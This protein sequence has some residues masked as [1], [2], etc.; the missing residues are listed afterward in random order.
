MITISDNAA[1]KIKELI[2]AESKPG[3]AFRVKVVAGGCSGFSYELGFDDQINADD[4][5]YEEKGVKVLLDA[6]SDT[7]VEGSQIDY[8]DGLMDAGFKINNP[9]VKG[10]CGCGT[11]FEL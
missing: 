11:S 7:A 4:K 10:S 9:K 3:L 6:Q 2:A 5:V 1:S 8:A